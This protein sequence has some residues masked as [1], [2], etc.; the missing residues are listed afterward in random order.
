LHRY[1][2]RFWRSPSDQITQGQQIIQ[3]DNSTTGKF[4]P[5][6]VDSFTTSD[7]ALQFPTSL[8]NK[9]VIVQ[10]LDGGTLGIDGSSATI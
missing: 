1:G 6:A 2:R 8:A 4:Q 3:D 5:V 7:V 9:S 10:A